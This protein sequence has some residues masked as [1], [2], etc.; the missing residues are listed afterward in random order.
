MIF[1]ILLALVAFLLGPIGFFLARGA[2]RDLRGLQAALA[3][4]NARL[5]ALEA[6]APGAAP[7][8]PVTEPEVAPPVE[9]PVPEPPLRRPR[10]MSAVD[11][12]SPET[13]SPSPAPAAGRGLEESLGTRWTVW[14]GGV[15]LALGAILLVKY[16]IE[17]GFFGPGV[18][19]FFGGALALALV[20]AGEFLRRRDPA[21]EYASD[22]VVRPP[23][24]PGVL[25][26]AGTVAAFATL[27]AAHALYGFIGPGVAF[28]LMGATGVATMLAAAL[29]GP[30]LAGLGL[31]GAFA[32]PALV[33]S[34][35]P[36]P[37]PLVI[38]CAVIAASAYGL[39]RLRRWLWLALAAAVGASLWGALLSAAAPGAETAGTLAAAA[40]AHLV[41]QTALGLYFV[42]VQ[43][44]PGVADED[45]RLDIPAHLVGA[46][47]AALAVITLGACLAAGQYGTFWQICGLAVVGLM[48]GCAV[49][50]APAAG[51]AILG[52]LVALL[53]L[54]FWPAEFAP[55]LVLSG[56]EIFT[57]RTQPRD[58]T[59]FALFALAAA[60]G[61]SAACGWRL[62]TATA[63]RLPVAAIFAG[64]A[65][66][67][68][69]AALGLVFLR[70][71]RG[72][73]SAAM[74][75]AAAVLAIAFVYAARL[76][77]TSRRFAESPTV[78][79]GLGAFASAAIAALALGFVFILEGGTLTVALALAALGAA[80]VSDRFEIPALRWCVCGFGLLVAARYA[81][82]PRIVG[83]ALGAT[84]V[85][86]WLLFGYGAPAA[87]FAYAARI[88]A[89]RGDDTPVRVAD[90]CA[91]L[92]AALLVFFE[93]RHGVNNG[94]AFARSSG[95]VEQG[96]MAMCS[97]AFSVVLMSLDARRANI[98]C[99]YASMA[100]AFLGIATAVVGLGFVQNPFFTGRRIEGGALFNGLILGYV[101]PGLAAFVLA[102]RA[103]ALGRR[104]VARAAGISTIGF[105]FLYATLETRRLFHDERIGWLRSTSD[106][107]SWSYSAVWLALGIFLLAY[108]LVR[109]SLE[110]RIAS[111]LFIVVT[112]L[113]VFLLDLAGLD[114]I[115]RALS[116]IGLGAVLIGIGLVYQKIVFARPAGTAEP[117]SS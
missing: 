29:H 22:S 19:T 66:L 86:N 16:S 25:T 95:L 11:V 100:A 72:E 9:E 44:N 1:L 71:T 98:V 4:T 113:K 82:D 10:W 74:A 94:N 24:I 42:A 50:I 36:S 93:I 53:A 103:R 2:R 83:P 62:F 45:A 57:N 60:G 47:F 109:Q 117:A 55:P 21:P 90:G 102:R 59:T 18:R 65:G 58:P 38:Y 15:A 46:L 112:V 48:V 81:W 12:S 76:F 73:S 35:D 43:P 14:V 84:P 5:A 80:Y 75:A 37:W 115:F 32:T 99:R 85:F 89:R 108:G 20:A 52:S 96:L 101:L 17:Q 56:E 23:H 51:L 114:G 69:L 39:A 97:F 116:F 111:A 107:E 27:W 105:L 61:A 33:S 7:A 31:V 106:A 8:P 49:R 87:A 77:Q 41:L 40:L 63:L 3:E 68:P 54:W 79:L 92:F 26:A 30:A 78:R 104:W 67:A 70:F 28:V 6:R 13:P 64:V 91:V 88:L 110:A 34:D